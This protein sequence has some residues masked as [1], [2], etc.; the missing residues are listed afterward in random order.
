VALER[1]NPLPPNARYW[2]HVPPADQPAF[3]AW[4][5]AYRGA[6]KVRSTQR[7]PDNGWD[8]VLFEVVAPL[9][10]WEG[11]GLPTKAEDDVK[12]ESDVVQ[13]P[14]VESA[15]AKLER[16]GDSVVG[17]TSKLAAIGVAIA[18]AAV[19]LNRGLR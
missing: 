18:V 8:W 12:S 4:L 10:W 13:V 14:I 5:T 3:T 11:P 16:L 1:S 17:G 19:V 6:V 7:D 15:T 9:V 2:V